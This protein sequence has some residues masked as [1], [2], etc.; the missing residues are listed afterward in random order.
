MFTLTVTYSDLCML[1]EALLAQIAISK[2]EMNGLSKESS[3]YRMYV[4]DI[5]HCNELL[6]TLKNV[7]EKET[8]SL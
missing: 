4:D 8:L 1:S 6:G 2:K 7:Y 3:L 5:N